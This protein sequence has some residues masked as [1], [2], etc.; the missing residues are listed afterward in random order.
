MAVSAKASNFFWREILKNRNFAETKIKIEN[1]RKL[2]QT[3]G[4]NLPLRELWVK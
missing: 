3:T 2:E 4:S 1:S